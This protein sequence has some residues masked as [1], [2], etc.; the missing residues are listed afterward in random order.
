MVVTVEIDGE[1]SERSL[2]A[3]ASH[4]KLAIVDAGFG[5]DDARTPGPA[6]QQATAS[7]STGGSA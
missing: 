5:L 1:T 7:A 6:S 3:A 4:H 2:V